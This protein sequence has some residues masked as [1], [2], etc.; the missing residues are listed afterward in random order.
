MTGSCTETPI[1]E[2]RANIEER[3][4]RLPRGIE[5]AKDGPPCGQVNV[6]LVDSEGH[7]GHL[8]E[9]L[10]A[11]GFGVTWS[12]NENV[13]KPA[14][15]ADAAGAAA[16]LLQVP[17]GGRLNVE[18]LGIAARHARGRPI[19][20]VGDRAAVSFIEEAVDWGVDDFI[21]YPCALEELSLRLTAVLGRWRSKQDELRELRRATTRALKKWFEETIG[22]TNA[23]LWSVAFYCGFLTMMEDLPDDVK[24]CLLHLG[25]GS[26]ALRRSVQDA[27]RLS[28]PSETDEVEKHSDTTTKG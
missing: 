7:A 20:L 16:V 11:S 26:A 15:S 14:V 9:D 3:L 19:V 24:A 22:T 28:Q 12:V 27:L 4:D 8:A 6:L 21:L 23:H 13:G 1:L 25:S 10:H 18:V 5:A 2:K 17:L